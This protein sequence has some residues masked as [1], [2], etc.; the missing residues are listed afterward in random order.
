M[1]KID[2]FLHT[3]EERLQTLEEEKEELKEYQK[4]DKLR[5]S[6]EYC[7]HDRDLKDTKRKL[8][9]VC[10]FFRHFSSKNYRPNIHIWF[11]LEN[12]LNNFDEEQKKLTSRVKE[13][14]DEAKRATKHL[15]DAKK[16]VQTAKEEKET[17]SVEKEQLLKEKTRLDFIIK[18]LTDEVLGDNKSKVKIILLYSLLDI[19]ALISPFFISFIFRIVLSKNL[20]N[21][22]KQS[23]VKKKN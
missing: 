23:K 8:E 18:D 20:K 21:Y 19:F 17:I 1:E 15:K 10:Q 4:W 11:Q 16:D 5:R 2:E 22:K 7:I 9:D 13:A 12:R 14:A 3:I 6:L